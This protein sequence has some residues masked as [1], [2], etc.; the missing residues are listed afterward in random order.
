MFVLTCQAPMKVLTAPCCCILHISDMVGFPVLPWVKN[1]GSLNFWCTKQSKLKAVCQTMPAETGIALP[2]GHAWLSE[3]PP[4]PAQPNRSSKQHSSTT[5]EASRLLYMCTLWNCGCSS[6]HESGKSSSE[7]DFS[8]LSSLR[9]CCRWS[10]S[11]QNSTMHCH[12]RPDTLKHFQVLVLYPRGRDTAC[13]LCPTNWKYGSRSWS[14]DS[15]CMWMPCP[16]FHTWTSR[17]PKTSWLFDLQQIIASNWR[18]LDSRYLWAHDAESSSTW[19]LALEI[20]S[21]PVSRFQSGHVPT[22]LLCT[23]WINL[24]VYFPDVSLQTVRCFDEAPA[25]MYSGL[26][27]GSAELWKKKLNYVTC[28][29]PCCPKSFETHLQWILS[30]FASALPWPAQKDSCL[31]TEW[32]LK[33][34]KG[35]IDSV[36]NQVWLKNWRASKQYL[37]FS[38]LGFH[39]ALEGQHSLSLLGGMSSRLTIRQKASGSKAPQV[40]LWPLRSH[41]PLRSSDWSQVPA[42]DLILPKFAITSVFSPCSTDTTAWPLKWSVN[43]SPA[44]FIPEV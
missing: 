34:T 4:P 41:R 9:V 1:D 14:Q 24:L 25:L 39:H 23:S 19:S 31:M 5:L 2:S 42:A 16:S 35:R 36:Q 12:A 22:S 28:T 3:W 27:K 43:I 18:D 11:W 44:W 38:S 29:P 37:H 30:C 7:W 20:T 32:N 10:H 40:D 26:W 8:V 15:R 6:R 13:S 33:P 21:W 17:L